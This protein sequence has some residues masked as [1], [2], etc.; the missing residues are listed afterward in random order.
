MG[1]RRDK[2]SLPCHPKSPIFDAPMKE[3][4]SLPSLKLLNNQIREWHDLV[5][6]I[7]CL[8]LPFYYKLFSSALRKTPK[9]SL[10]NLA[11]ILGS[12]SHLG[13]G[14]Q[15]IPRYS[16]LGYDPTT[17][18]AIALD[19]WAATIAQHILLFP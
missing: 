14:P 2:M 10:S 4:H 17:Q 8:F 16:S 7:P 13:L 9:Y 1:S 11:E 6:S 15:A 18:A 19:C 3:A 5:H 12:F